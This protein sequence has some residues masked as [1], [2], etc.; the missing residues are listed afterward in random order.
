MF[1]CVSRSSVVLTLSVGLCASHPAWSQGTEPL[2]P[3]LSGKWTYVPP[4]G[5]TYNDA[6]SVQFEGTPAGGAIKGKV[7]WRGR[8]CGAQDEPVNAQWDGVE[9]RFRF[10]ARPNVNASVPNS[11]S[12]GEGTTDV[13]LRR[14]PGGTSFEGQASFNHGA[15]I[16]EVSA[17][18]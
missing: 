6:W 10:I 8:G 2:P 17:A 12:C 3:S 1:A 11:P 15:A 4:N 7:N 16:I 9:L 18:P 13:V 5:R 14:K